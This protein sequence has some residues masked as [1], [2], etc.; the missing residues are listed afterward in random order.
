[1]QLEEAKVLLEENP[2]SAY[3]YL[4]SGVK[5]DVCWIKNNIKETR[6]TKSKKQFLLLTVVSL[7][8]YA[9]SSSVQNVTT[10]KLDDAQIVVL[11]EAKV[12]EK[13]TVKLSDLVEDFQVVRFDNKDEAFFKAFW[14]NCSDNYICIRQSGNPI[15]LF[16]K[17]G[18]YLGNVGNIGQGPGEYNHFYDILLDG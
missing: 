8:L 16:D 9:C 3:L 4:Q 6:K 7:F 13:K 10:V 1:M 14:I 2:D 15:K 11:D 18:R 5:S 12:T 17:S